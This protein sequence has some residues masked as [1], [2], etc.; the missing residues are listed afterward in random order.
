M[1]VD[2]RVQAV[3]GFVIDEVIGKGIINGGDVVG[4]ICPHVIAT[5]QRRIPQ[6]P[7]HLKT[8]A[9]V[10]AIRRGLH[11]AGGIAGGRVTVIVQHIAG[12]EIGATAGF[13]HQPV[14]VER[15]DQRNQVRRVRLAGI[16]L[17]LPFI[18]CVPHDDAR[19]VPVIGDQGRQFG[20]EL[21]GIDRLRAAGVGIAT[22]HILPDQQA[23]PVRPII[24]ALPFHLDMLAHHIKTKRLGHLQII[25]LR[26]IG[27]RGVKSVRP[28][29]L[30]Q[31]P[32]FKIGLIVQEHFGCTVDD[33]DGN[34]PHPK[35]TGDT[36]VGH[37][38]LN[39]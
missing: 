21:Q 2:R 4:S 3:A 20:D 7:G 5:G 38:V 35:V 9:A 29:P 13:V 25:R 8:D 39:H 18:E 14:R 12:I 23:Q 32:H 6:V 22:R 28:E 17:P 27:G 11:G 10:F 36:V 24:P 26:G 34:F 15:F 31:R 30:I 37:P 19:T 33:T 1:R 16:G